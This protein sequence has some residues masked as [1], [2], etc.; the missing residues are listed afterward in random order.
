MGHCNTKLIESTRIHHDINPNN[1]TRDD[2]FED[3]CI[4]ITNKESEYL[5]AYD[6]KSRMRIVPHNQ[7]PR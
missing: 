2:I 7:L 6:T 1:I 5:L 4:K 3:N